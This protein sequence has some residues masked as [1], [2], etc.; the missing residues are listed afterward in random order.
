MK[1]ITPAE[2]SEFLLLGTRTAKVATVRSNGAPH[3]APVWFVLDGNELVF[4]TG[5]DKDTVKGKDLFRS[6]HED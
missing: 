6:S 4:T 3:V 5:K 1:T 2:W